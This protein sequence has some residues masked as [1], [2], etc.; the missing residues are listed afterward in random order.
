MTGLLEAALAYAA[1]GWPVFPC[2]PGSK[3][4]A[5]KGG[6]GVLDA[7]TDPAQIRAWW[8]TWP[9]ANVAIATGAPGPDVLDVDVKDDGGYTG[10]AAFKE[11]AQAGLTT[12]AG[13][14]VETPSGGMH[15]YYQGTSQRNGSIRKRH[16]DFRSAGGYVVAPPSIVDGK[17]YKVLLEDGTAT[18]AIDWGAIRALLDPP[19][20]P[21]A[22][23]QPSQDTPAQPAGS[24]PGDQW[25]AAT[26]WDQI[27]QPAGWRKVRDLGGGRACWCRPGKQGGFTSATTRD[28]GGL[29]VFSTSTEFD[30]EVPYSKFGALAVLEHHGDHAATAA[31][32]R[33]DGYG[34][35]LPG[36]APAG[37]LAPGRHEAPPPAGAFPIADLR[38]FL[39]HGVPAPVL[40]PGRLLYQGGIHLIAGAPDCGKTTLCLWT[41]LTALRSGHRVMMLD[42]EGGSE[43]IAEKLIAL[44]ATEDDAERLT[45]IEFPGRG[46]NA[47]D[48]GELHALTAAVEPSM[49]LFDSCAA[50]MARAGLDEN[51]ASDVTIWWANVLTPL[52]RTFRAAVTVIDHDG[53]DG[54]ESRYSRGSGAKL[55]ASDVMIKVDMVR[56]FSRSMNGALKLA[57]TKDRRGHLHRF[58]D[59]VV[60][61]KDGLQLSIAESDMT[62]RKRDDLTP[63]A[64]GLLAVLDSTPRSW[65][66][67]VDLFAAEHGHGLRRP[68]ASTALNRLLELGLAD[69]LEQ[70]ARGQ[71]L[72]SLNDS[73]QAV[74]GE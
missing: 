17:P 19:P 56:P 15:A 43:T 6:R 41:A 10:Y 63:A 28:D 50:F 66:E 62:P 42:E 32:L 25:A 9:T 55:A 54:T 65:K 20:D 53:K 45:Y 67:L 44:G 2:A 35:P 18:A 49:I 59:V 3:V 30:P 13:A 29:Y 39:R 22:F 74:D 34:E 72:W 31:Q 8:D 7:T 37:Q 71:A 23:T 21:P 61:T 64:E 27:L 12:A 14:Y 38:K 47:A 36:P 52:A 60:K 24:R 58:F 5:V 16:V 46:W 51:S 70:G 48:V 11:A 73:N 26:T 57:V 69:R 4:P 40:L 33:R 1:R 68:T